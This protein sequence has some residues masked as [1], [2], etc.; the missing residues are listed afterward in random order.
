M[1]KKLNINLYFD[2]NSYK[3]PVTRLQTSFNREVEVFVSFPTFSSTYITAKSLENSNPMLP[4][5]FYKY[6][7]TS[8]RDTAVMSFLREDFVWKIRGP[9]MKVYK[10]LL[11]PEFIPT[12]VRLRSVVT[13]EPLDEED[14]V[15][16]INEDKYNNLLDEYIATNDDSIDTCPITCYNFRIGD[17]I[18][19]TKCGHKFTSC[20]LRK[21]LLEFGNTCPMC[22]AKIE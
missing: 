10:T 13:N 3:M 11:H 15:T 7:M 18:A 16:T 2:T 17:T 9:L 19:K 22:R 8:T 20:E 12:A 14:A 4:R 5:Y 6:D 1:F 21:Y